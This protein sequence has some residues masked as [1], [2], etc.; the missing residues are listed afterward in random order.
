MGETE[1]TQLVNW[2]HVGWSL[3]ELT[4]TRISSGQIFFLKFTFISDKSWF[5]VMVRKITATLLNFSLHFWDEK[6]RLKIA[7]SWNGQKRMY[8]AISVFRTNFLI[9]EYNR[10]NKWC[11]TPES[12]TI[13]NAKSVHISTRFS[14]LTN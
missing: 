5:E 11:K 13:K 4:V 10:K 6:S 7:S 12:L 1:T 8:H 3:Y 9:Y 2:S 14:P